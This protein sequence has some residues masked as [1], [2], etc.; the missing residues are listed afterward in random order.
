MRR[1]ALPT[2]RPLASAA[3][4][5]FIDLIALTPKDAPAPRHL[6]QK[7]CGGGI[8]GKETSARAAVSFFRNSD[9]L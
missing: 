3:Q 2:V 8:I 6:D 7:G 4:N 9:E 5:H 1:Q